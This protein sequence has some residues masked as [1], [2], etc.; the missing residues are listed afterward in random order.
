[1]LNIFPTRITESNNKSLS[2]W[3]EA[4]A[5]AKQHIHDF[6]PTIRIFE[7][8]MDAG[9]QFPEPKKRRSWKASRGEAKP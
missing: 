9:M 6:K 2:R 3:D 4:I 8:F 5:V 7:S 1:M